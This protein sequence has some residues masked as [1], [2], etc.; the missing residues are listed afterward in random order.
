MDLAEQTLSTFIKQQG[1][2]ICEHTVLN[3]FLSI[4]YG[5]KYLHENNIIHRDIKPEKILM[6]GQLTVN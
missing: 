1:N 4:L 6:K 5:L 3:I 2:L